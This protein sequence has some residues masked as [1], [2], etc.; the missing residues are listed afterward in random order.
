[1]LGEPSNKN[2]KMSS[3]EKHEEKVPSRERV[4]SVENHKGKKEES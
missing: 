1:M 3:R 4:P 2:K